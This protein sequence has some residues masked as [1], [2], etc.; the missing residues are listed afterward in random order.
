MELQIHMTEDG[1]KNYPLHRHANY[2]IML[3]VEGEGVLRTPKKDHPF[4]KGTVIIVPPAVEH[5]SVSSN[6]FK[7]ISIGGDIDYL[8]SNSDIVVLNDNSRGDASVL[9]RMIYENRYESRGYLSALCNAYI[10]CLL[11]GLNETDQLDGA[12]SAV[13]AEI[14]E[15]FCE[16]DLNTANLL[17]KSG[18]AQDYIRARF[19][20]IVGYPPN[21]FLTKTRIDRAC[22]LIEVYGASL[23]FSEI[24]NRCGYLDYAYF[25]KKFKSVTG[26]SPME[27][28]KKREV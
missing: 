8:L 4:K 23:S 21:G 26:L 11:N 24:A 27:Y 20:Q 14:T 3:Y 6:G 19:K 10:H 25:S 9:A 22:F 7:N 28:K 1:V 12:V 13:V 18:F 17:D 16:P 2:E 15:R 5:G